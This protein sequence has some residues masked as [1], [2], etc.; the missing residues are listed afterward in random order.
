MSCIQDF[1]FAEKI[2]D[3]ILVSRAGTPG[4]IPPEIFKLKPYIDKG[5]VFSVG[6]IFFSVMYQLLCKDHGR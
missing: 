6:V 3:K 2:N 1:G 4:F 5:D